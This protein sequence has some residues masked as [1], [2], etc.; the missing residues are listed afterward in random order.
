MAFTVEKSD[1]FE[2]IRPEN[3]RKL[4]GYETLTNKVLSLVAKDTRFFSEPKLD[5][6]LSEHPRMIVIFNHSSPLSWIP[7]PCLLASHINARGGGGRTP[8]AVMDRFFF[9]VPGLRQVARYI[10]QS[11]RP[12]SFDELVGHFEKLKT[13][14][15][16]LFPEGSNAFFGEPS[17]IQPFRSTRFVEIAMRT[18]TPL[19]LCVHRGSENWAKTIRIDQSRLRRLPKFFG[20]LLGRRL[21]AGGMLTLPVFPK[22][23]PI[24]AMR[25]EIF[26]PDKSASLQGQAEKVHERMR[27]MLAHLDRDLT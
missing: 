7:A 5:L 21:K 3:L 23:M 18:K 8:I 15:L 25:C 2:N 4:S 20:K 10:T 1:S 24:F 9:K 14:D 6:I 19:L 17:E 11:P 12:L 16:V 13:A 26:R 27:L 22:R